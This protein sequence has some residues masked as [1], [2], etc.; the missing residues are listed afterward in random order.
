MTRRR[1]ILLAPVIVVAALLT[2]PPA[3]AAPTTEVIQGS[4]LRIVSVADWTAASS[5]MPGESVRWDVAVSAD[6]PDPGRVTLSV[7]ASG[8]APLV[9]DAELCMRGWQADGC[10]GGAMALRSSW[11]IPLDGSPVVLAEIATTEVARLR[12]RIALGVAAGEASGATDVRVRAS[13]VGDS[14]VVGP[15]G[16]LPATGGGVL[17]ATGGGVVPWVVGV[18]AGLVIAGAGVLVPRPRRRT[19]RADS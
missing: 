16:P 7:S 13:G 17:P 9:V 1:V 10:P 14:V 18:A 2:A 6:A 19:G 3:W 11:A 8:D 15:G 5:L 12:L 4:V